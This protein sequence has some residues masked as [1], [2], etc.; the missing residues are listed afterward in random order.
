MLPSTVQPVR[1][2]IDTL[3][4][5][6]FTR[7]ICVRYVAENT[8]TKPISEADFLDDFVGENWDW[9]DLI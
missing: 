4:L 5:S 8:R 1:Y 9:Y 3:Q 6:R 7:P 2:P